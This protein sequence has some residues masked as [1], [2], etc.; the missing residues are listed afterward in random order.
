MELQPS[1]LQHEFKP[2]SGVDSYSSPLDQ[3]QNRST[4]M[5]VVL[6]EQEILK[7]LEG[8]LKPDG[9]GNEQAMCGCPAPCA[10][11]GCRCMGG[12]Q[13]DQGNDD[14]NESPRP[15]S[16]GRLNGMVNR[17]EKMVDQAAADAD[18]D[19]WS[20]NPNRLNRLN[21]TMDQLMGGVD[22]LDHGGLQPRARQSLST[23]ITRIET[24][25][26]RFE[27]TGVN[28]QLASK[29]LDRLQSFNAP[30]WME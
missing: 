24:V 12:G 26:A 14:G 18:G 11:S 19:W 27:D 10:C 22:G 21:R 25:F 3:G 8:V 2:E 23:T 1:P 4:P 16:I 5:G 7:D 28:H 20:D 17:L 29:I 13:P 6:S 9:K 15:S 30:E